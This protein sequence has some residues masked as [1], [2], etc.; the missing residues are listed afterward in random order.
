M[1]SFDTFDHAA[2]RQALREGLVAG[3]L[4]SLLSTAVLAAAGRRDAGSAWAPVNAV[5]HWLWG[6]EALEQDEPSWRYTGVG[7]LTHHLSAVFWAVLHARI[8]AAQPGSGSVP[9]VLA[10]SAATSA[11]AAAIDYTLVPERLT[12]GFEHR[13]T[14]GSMVAVF[15]ALATG[16][17]LGSLM[18]RD[19]D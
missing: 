5:S 18:L 6:R 9:A 2:W 7:L 14:T 11:A 19:R 12:P 1:N 8:A 10:G 17:T 3:S 16:L 4:A 15:V 13:L